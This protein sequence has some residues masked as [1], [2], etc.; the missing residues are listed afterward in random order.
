MQ[1]RLDVIIAF[2]N[3]DYANWQNMVAEKQKEFESEIDKIK[4]GIKEFTDKFYNKNT[5]ENRRVM[6]IMKR[7]PGITSQNHNYEIEKLKKYY[8]KKEK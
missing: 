4:N 6:N 5:K 1:K 3:D 7:N 2:A 8:T